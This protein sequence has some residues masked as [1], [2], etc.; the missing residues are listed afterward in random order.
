ME[1]IE[2]AKNR[3]ETT[4]DGKNGFYRGVL[5]ANRWHN[6]YDEKPSHREIV[7]AKVPLINYP[8]LFAY[9][10]FEGKW[11][12]FNK[13]DFYLSAIVPIEWRPIE[14]S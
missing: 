12:Q 2:Q 13:G 14:R 1:K 5:W 11:Y 4:M 6:T 8:L 3:L 7:L 10:E 9:N